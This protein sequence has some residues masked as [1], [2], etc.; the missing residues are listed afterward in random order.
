MSCDTNDT[1][2]AIEII[3]QKGNTLCCYIIPSEEQTS[4][5]SRVNLA[6]TFRILYTSCIAQTEVGK[7]N[8]IMP[9]I[10]YH[11]MQYFL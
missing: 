7:H 1:Y 8:Y 11:L 2:I 10:I 6:L 5:D 3:K 4:K 9:T